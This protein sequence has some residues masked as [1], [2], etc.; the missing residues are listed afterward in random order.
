LGKKTRHG[1]SGIF[2]SIAPENYTT[3]GIIQVLGKTQLE[4]LTGSIPDDQPISPANSV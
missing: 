3:T 4:A 2:Q 1:L